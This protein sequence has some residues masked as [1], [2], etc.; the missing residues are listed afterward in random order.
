MEL[1]KEMSRRT[2]TLVLGGARSGKSRYAQELASAFERVVYIATAQRVDAE[3]RAKI[4]RHQSERPS[5][6]KT[7][8][9]STELGRTLRNES[10]QADLLLVD[11]LTCYVANIMGRKKYAGRKK[12]LDYIDPL[13][14]AVRDAKAS[15]VLVSNEVGCG[16][17][18]AYQSGRVYRDLL[19]ELNQQ[20]AKLADRVIFMVAGLPLSVKDCSQSLGR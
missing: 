13:C 12:I 5:A 7:V 16:V 3:M 10:A 2:V 9:V 15:V 1:K 8:E 4:A 11:C 19:G 6:W 14:E 17:V 18:P 20:I